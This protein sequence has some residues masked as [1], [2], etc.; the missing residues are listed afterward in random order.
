MRVN[1]KGFFKKNHNRKFLKCLS[2]SKLINNTVLFKGNDTVICFKDKDIW[3]ND[4]KISPT[5][6]LVRCTVW[7][8]FRFGSSK[9]EF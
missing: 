6:E 2:A 5:A 4:K 1:S 7:F 3:I 9:N 8:N